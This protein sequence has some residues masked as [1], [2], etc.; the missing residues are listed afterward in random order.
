MPKLD[1]IY[2][3]LRE[4]TTAEGDIVAMGW[5]R[6]LSIE[7]N[8]VN[9]TLVIPRGKEQQVKVDEIRSKLLEIEGVEEVE[10]D[11]RVVEPTQQVSPGIPRVIPGQVK[12]VLMVTSGK[13]GVGKSTVAANIAI[14]LTK[15]GY[16]IGLLDGDLYGPSIPKMFGIE[17]YEVKVINNKI[18]PVVRYD[19]KV[20]SIGLLLRRDQA[21]V[22]RGPLIHKAYQQFLSDVDWGSIDLLVMDLPPGTGDPQLSATQI[23]PVKGGIAVTTPQDVSLSDVRRAIS[24]MR[25]V[26][27][28]VLGIVENMSYLTCPHCGYRIKIFGEGG[29]ERL[30]KETGTEL[31]GKVPFDPEV[32]NASDRGKPPAAMDPDSPIGKAFT[33]IAEK[34]AKKL[35]KTS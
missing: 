22:W 34:L 11:L 21:V 9:F 24:M 26:N 18:I 19:V 12:S 30:A 10:V 3:K 8:R 29:G 35:F 6:N 33:H 25:T 31:L 15:M 27:V 17:D 23:M 2:S 7:D 4:F 5:V 1:D 20:L 14:A 16:K 32:V 13:G 28:P